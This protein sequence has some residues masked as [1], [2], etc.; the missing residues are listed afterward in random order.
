[1]ILV[2]TDESGV[3]T[4]LFRA[5]RYRGASDLVALSAAG[6]GFSLS[7]GS[8]VPM[9]GLSSFRLVPA[10][11]RESN[12]RGVAEALQMAKVLGQLQQEAD[13]VFVDGPPLRESPGG[14]KLAAAVDGVVLVVRRGT[15]L[16]QL[17]QTQTL[18]ARAQA[19]IVGF[20]FDRSRPAS[21]WRPWRR[22][23][24]KSQGRRRRSS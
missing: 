4:S 8:L 16:D 11:T 3:L 6:L 2:D 23:P 9:E 24:D 7:D 10:G 5:E 12:G 20:V 15:T 18:L 17:R 13:L 1:V 14:M 22:W 19:P 21:R